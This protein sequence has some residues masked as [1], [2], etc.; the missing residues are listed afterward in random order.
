MALCAADPACQQPLN[1]TAQ[2]YLGQNLCVSCV[3]EEALD[4]A[5][6]FVIQAVTTV[7][8]SYP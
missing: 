2:T 7:I 5:V 6:V 1:A 3:P 4:R 8:D